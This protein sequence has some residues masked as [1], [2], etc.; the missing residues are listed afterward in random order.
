[1]TR[2][3]PG[4]HDQDKHG[5]GGGSD[6]LGIADRI[7]LADGESLVSS[8]RFAAGDSDSE[9]VWAVTST[10]DGRTARVAVIGAEAAEEWDGTGDLTTVLDRGQV[11]ALRGDL[12]AGGATSKATAAKLTKLDDDGEDVDEKYFDEPTA[13]GRTAD[14]R[15]EMWLDGMDPLSY[16]V[17]L[18]VGDDEEDDGKTLEPKDLRKLLKKLAA[19][20]DDLA[21][22]DA[23]QYEPTEWSKFMH[24]MRNRRAGVGRTLGYIDRTAI[25]DGQP[26]R[27]IMA[28]EGRKADGVDLRMAGADL[29]R[30]RANPV[31]GY[32]HAYWGRDNLPIGR[33]NPDSIGVAGTS[34]AGDL[35]FDQGDPFAREI[36]RKMRDGYMSAVS[37]GFEVLEWEDGKGDLWRG[38]VATKWALTELSVVPIGMDEK[39]LVTAGRSLID[40]FDRDAMRALV[41]EF[42][43]ERVMAALIGSA[44]PPELPAPPAQDPK[45][46]EPAGFSVP[47]DAARALLAAFA[48]ES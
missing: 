11:D 30:Y 31:L 5:D 42:G 27:V 3:L 9:V 15:W 13:S 37:I 47:T 45:P 40:E 38:G 12:E 6:L 10:A 17:E 21:G 39:A 24:G 25:Q 48:K 41:D 22:G 36:E 35:D 7:K 23:R 16:V 2:H 34:L 14:L 19:L 33:V 4:E 44:P 1:V 8:G 20:S 43:A 29:A 26:L 46:A 18:H 28:T 32:G